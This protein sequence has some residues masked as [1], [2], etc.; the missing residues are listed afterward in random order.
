[1]R[2]SSRTRC[3]CLQQAL[4]PVDAPGAG[5]SRAGPRDSL[6]GEW[7]A[8]ELGLSPAAM[9][10]PSTFHFTSGNGLLLTDLLLVTFSGPPSEM[11]E[12]MKD[13]KSRVEALEQV[14]F[15]H[16]PRPCPALTA[17][18]QLKATLSQLPPRALCSQG[19]PP[20]QLY[21]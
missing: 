10:L 6:G 12:E 4:D 21:F 3:Q 7:K 18:S 11:K 1:M 8:A 5:P 9:S 15:Q 19:F 16:T 20:P 14:S 2:V 17:L 13:L